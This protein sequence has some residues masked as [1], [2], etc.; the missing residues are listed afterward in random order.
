M[1]KLLLVLALI[2]A[3]S[4]IT[5]KG[6]GGHSSGGGG[7]HSSG[8]GGGH[9]SGGN[10]GGRSRGGYGRGYGG[11]FV[12]DVEYVADDIVDAPVAL[13]DDYE[14]YGYDGGYYGGG[15]RGGNDGGNGRNRGNKFQRSSG[16]TRGGGKRK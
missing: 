3:V 12:G 7:G 10:R 15:R 8:G 5:P 14:G 1:K 9:S 6:G 16:H 13:Y 11:G 2:T 4:E